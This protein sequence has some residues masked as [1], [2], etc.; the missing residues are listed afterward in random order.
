MKD[1]KR[2]LTSKTFWLSLVG[3]IVVAL[4]CFGVKVDAP[5]VNEA[6]SAVCSV[7]IVL[8]IVKNDSVLPGS[9][10]D[11]DDSK[12]EEDYKDAT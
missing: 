3:A 10:E 12:Q 9:G 8:G 11:E 2:K 6:V 4:Q 1:L 7:F 5:Y